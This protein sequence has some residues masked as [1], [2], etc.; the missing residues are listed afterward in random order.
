MQAQQQ[1]QQ[2]QF[3][4]PMSFS[5]MRGGGGSFGSHGPPPGS[6]PPQSMAPAASAPLPRA[7]YRRSAI[8]RPAAMLHLAREPPG[9]RA[10]IWD[11]YTPPSPEQA[12][13]SEGA[14]SVDPLQALATLQ[15][16]EG[17]WQWTLPL[18]VIL[19]FTVG[20]A[21]AAAPG[22]AD[23]VLATACAVAYLK[24]KLTHDKDTWEMMVEK[25][26]KWLSAQG[27]DVGGLEKAVQA[28][29]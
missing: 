6:L 11:D 22:Y 2:Q 14:L 15:R 21:K 8:R 18:E 19:G 12:S 23:E 3:Q 16:F 17:N 27:G 10:S 25:A 9:G 28:L 24:T 29:F 5:S 20:A 26:E 4:E 13:I 1:Q 7:E